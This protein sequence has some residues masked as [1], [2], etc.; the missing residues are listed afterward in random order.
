MFGVGLGK[1]AV[2]VPGAPL[3]S[4]HVNGDPLQENLSVF[5]V[6]LA[7]FVPTRHEAPP[8][9]TVSDTDA[10]L[11]ALAVFVVIDCVGELIAG[12]PGVLP[13]AEPKSLA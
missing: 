3:P 10:R 5:T 4:V 13:A 11:Q 2:T 8:T 7:S 9:V 1:V 12:E 6:K